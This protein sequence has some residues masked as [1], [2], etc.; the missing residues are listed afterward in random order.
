MPP[1]FLLPSSIMPV[2]S[3]RVCRFFFPALQPACALF[4]LPCY[5]NMRASYWTR[6]GHTK[7]SLAQTN[8]FST[9]Q[10]KL[11][12]GTLDGGCA[13][14]SSEQLQRRGEDLVLK[15]RAQGV[16]TNK[17]YV[18]PQVVD[19][20]KLLFCK[21]H[22]VHLVPSS[23]TVIIVIPREVKDVPPWSL[24]NVLTVV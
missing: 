11:E 22:R 19:L 12:R 14:R 2:L 17:Q 15:E 5:H 1:L 24:N 18:V 6:A 10:Q 23:P 3:P 7:V 21:I 4:F 13:P 16:E 8:P 9:K 20:N